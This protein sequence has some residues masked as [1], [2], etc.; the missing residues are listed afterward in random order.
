MVPI[1][2]ELAFRGY[3]Y[4]V[5][6]STR[7]EEVDFRT[8]SWVALIVSSVLF[9]FMHDRWLSAAFAGAVYALLM[10]RSGQISDAIAAHMVTNAVVFGWA[11]ALHQW[12]LL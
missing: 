9:G 3:L 8:F 5:I 12:S 11:V 1:A 6:I 10:C 2:E 7:F 4:R